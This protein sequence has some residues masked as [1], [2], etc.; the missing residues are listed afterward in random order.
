MYQ[1]IDDH[2]NEGELRG[3]CADLGIDYDDLP[4]SS[5]ADKARELVLYCAR[6]G[7]RD[8]LKKRCREL[9]PNVPWLDSPPKPPKPQKVDPTDRKPRFPR[10]YVFI[11]VG[12]VI[13]ALVLLVGHVIY[14]T[15]IVVDTMDR[16]LGWSTAKDPQ[17]TIEIS[18]APGL[19]DNAIRMD[20]TLK[21]D[22]YVLIL[23]EIS[24]GQLSGTQSIRFHYMGTGRNTIELKLFYAPGGQDE[25]FTYSRLESANPDDWLPFEQLYR[26]FDCGN[27]C[28]APGQK[29]DPAKVRRLEIAVSHQLG[30]V[31]G[32]GFMIVD[33][34]EALR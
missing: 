20:Y 16:P 6:H 4:G 17:S 10:R 33:Q 26:A 19:L 5:K 7:R 14:K 24:P 2:F 3:L 31:P 15:P 23:K 25:A 9:R 21:Q 27:T 30:G 22:G 11:G 34:I 13:V 18:P 29:V 8:D 1:W 28:K 32:R 12:V